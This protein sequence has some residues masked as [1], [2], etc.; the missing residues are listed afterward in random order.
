MKMIQQARIGPQGMIRIFTEMRAEAEAASKLLQY[1]STHPQMQDRVEALKG[2]AAQ[3]RYTP[4]RWP[5]RETWSAIAG[6][7]RAP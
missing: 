1:L 7:C 4:V 2:Q 3:A 5:E 6:A